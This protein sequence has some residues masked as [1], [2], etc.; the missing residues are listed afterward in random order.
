[1]FLG[2]FAAQRLSPRSRI[3]F[4]VGVFECGSTKIKCFR[5]VRSTALP[6][7]GGI[8]FD[9]DVLAGTS[10]SPRFRSTKAVKTT[11]SRAPGVVLY[12]LVVV[13]SISIFRCR[14]ATYLGAVEQWSQRK[15]LVC[16]MT[17]VEYS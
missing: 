12:R 3:H 10:L 1:M 7:S 15:S 2:G 13:F 4:P 8:T 6:K 11:L 9:S 17:S 16:A 14:L 5:T